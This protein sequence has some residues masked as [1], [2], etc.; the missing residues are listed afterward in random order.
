PALHVEAEPP[1]PIATY[2]AFRQFSI[3]VS[4]IVEHFG[5]R[6]RVTPW[7]PANR[8]LVNVDDLVYCVQPFDAIMVASPFPRPIQHLRY[9]LVQ[10]LHQQR[11]FS[12]ATDTRN[13]HQLAQWNLYVHIFEVVFPR[14]PDRDGFPHSPPPLSWNRYLPPARKER[15]G[16]AV[17]V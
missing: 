2:L 6:R 13:H 1:R 17:R 16:D 4:D 10:N 15:P 14:P 5:I 8:C 12:T 3:Q 7:R 11:R 9:P